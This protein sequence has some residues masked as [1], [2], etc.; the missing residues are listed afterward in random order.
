MKIKTYQITFLP[1]ISFRKEYRIGPILFWPYDLMKNHKIIDKEV[2]IHLDK[3]FEQFIDYEGKKVDTITIC[4]FND[5]FLKI[6][7]PTEEEIL[8][9]S[10][11][12][13]I[14]STLVPQI[15]GKILNRNCP[16]SIPNSDIFNKFISNF[17][18]GTTQC[19]F[20]LKVGKMEVGKLETSTFKDPGQQVIVMENPMK[21]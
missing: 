9:W 1:W 7:D 18:P 15:K 21:N 4:T 10:I 20:Y 13:V 19:Q 8:N 5:N 12:S 6:L 2:I 3:Y 16:L 14:F 11:N 17:S